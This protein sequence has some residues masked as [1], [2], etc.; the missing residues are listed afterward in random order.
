MRKHFLKLFTALILLA[1]MML[2]GCFTRCTPDPY[3][4]DRTEGWEPVLTLKVDFGFGKVY[5]GASPLCDEFLDFKPYSAHEYLTEENFWPAAQEAMRLN[6]GDP[7]EELRGNTEVINEGGAI[8][9][10]TDRF[11]VV[12]DRPSG[13]LLFCADFEKTECLS[14]HNS[15]GVQLTVNAASLTADQLSELMRISNYY[16]IASELNLKG[17]ELPLTAQGA[18]ELSVGMDVKHWHGNGHR[19]YTT[20][21]A[22]YVYY[23]EVSN[24]MFVVANTYIQAFDVA[25]GKLLMMS[26]YGTSGGKV[27]RPWGEDNS[28]QLPG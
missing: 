1:A 2:S 22:F 21:G 5:A 20:G 10:V 13:K 7:H 28:Y 3:L 16:D 8:G 17:V 6:L 11:A 19:F 4:V 23:S 12:F 9:F 15:D 18:F 27:K 26:S 25:S 24:A 14:R